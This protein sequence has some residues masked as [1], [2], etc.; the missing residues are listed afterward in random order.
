MTIGSHHPPQRQSRGSRL[1]PCALLVLALAAGCG[2]GGG[3]SGGGTIAGSSG[4]PPGGTTTI[5]SPQDFVLQSAYMARPILDLD[6]ELQALLNPASLYEVDPVTGVPLP[7]F[8]APL[9][10][11][12]DLGTLAPINFAQILDPLTPQVPLVPRNAALVLEFSFPVDA[13]SLMLDDSDPAAPGKL[14]SASPLQVR[15]ADGS[16]VDARASVDGRQV[17]LFARSPTQAGWEASPLLFDTLGLAVEDP[18]GTLRVVMGTGVGLVPFLSTSG[19]ELVPRLPDHLGTLDVPLPVNPGNSEL[20]PLALQT[21][22]GVIHF[23]GFLPDLAAPRIVRPV[24]LTGTV[25]TGGVLGPFAV[26]GTALA[27]PA[28][29]AEDEFAG[30][31]A[32]ALLEIVGA[33]GKLTRYVVESNTS[34]TTVPAK[35]VY[36]LVAATPLDASVV[37]GSAYTVTRSEYYEPIPPPL[38]T[39]PEALAAITVDP[40]DHPREAEDPQ[41][42]INHDLRYF[43]RMYDE[44]GVERT[45]VWDPAANLFGAVKGKFEAVPPRTTLRIQFSEPM[46]PRSAR[47]YETFYVTEAALPKTDP[48]LRDQRLGRCTASTDLRTLSFE[49]FLEDQ[50]DDDGSQ[51]VGF[52]GTPA[53]L[54][55]VLRTLPEPDELAALIEGASPA[56]LGQFVDLELEGVLGLIDLG[57]RGLGL[58]EA[59]LDQGDP[60][61][62]LLQPASPGSGAYPPAVDFSVSFQTQPS[63]DPDF[64]AIVHRFM[65]QATSASFTYPA[66][67]IH[68]EVTTGVEYHDW[69][70]ED[71]DHDGNVDRRFIYGPILLDI[72][73]NLPGRLTGAP[74]NT[75]EHIVDDFNNPKPAPFSSPQGEDFLPTIGFGVRLP[76]NSP[77]GCRFQHIFRQ[78]EAS[79]SFHDYKGV[80]LDLVGLAWAPIGNTVTNETIEGISILVGLS[81]TNNCRGPNTNQ[82]G[83]IPN[84]AASGLNEQFDCNLLEWKEDCDLDK[85]DISADL[86]PHVA[87]Q[88]T[89]TEVV[90]GGTPYTISKAK[91]FKPANAQNKP[92]GQYNLYMNYPAFNSGVD[93]T[94]GNPNVD[95]FPYDSRFPMIVEYHIAPAVN[96]NPS[97]QNAYRFSPGIFSSV[98]PR[99]RIWSQGQD[100][101]ANCVPNMITLGCAPQPGGFP[102]GFKAGEGGPLV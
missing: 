89:L 16:L 81:A 101:L 41:D 68:D 84:D 37:A 67:S 11:G 27:I 55:L 35:P 63:D 3:G 20:D 22:A 46:E 31:W 24:V 17:S 39:D 86:Q 70:P 61:W 12:T 95:S 94:F 57:G 96:S 47:A 45:D 43:V 60:N 90:R 18:A 72:G 1:E 9:T 21:D 97:N 8:P 73:L 80:M 64:G 78:G 87:S 13:S 42:L 2:G 15:R 83:G 88:P 40:E 62:F 19:Q 10:P 79:P 44:A 33:G 5:N 58:P 66:A 56:Q 32:H 36:H 99:F 50:F 91:L 98:L 26:R 102:C 51:Y 82:G 49:P 7:G 92:T 29:P 76:L 30:E 54:K 28:V 71:A 23:N 4:G 34:D 75:I 100:P 14:T 74:A 48:A 69:P 52:G 65:G 59:M 6:G 77:Y 93:T 25:D 85:T 38:P 53:S